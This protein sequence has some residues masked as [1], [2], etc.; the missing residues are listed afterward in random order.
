MTTIEDITVGGIRFLDSTSVGRKAGAFIF[1]GSQTPTDL[2]TGRLVLGLRDLPPEVKSQFATG[3][4]L[5]DAPDDR[6]LAQAWRIFTNVEQ[7]LRDLGSTLD[8]I[9]HQRI[10]LRE[11]RDLPSVERVLR[12]F[13]PSDWPST[14]V[15]GATSDGVDP[16]IQIQADFVVLAPGSGLQ[17]ESVKL[18]E[19][20]HLAAPY[21][22]ATRAGRYIFTTPLAG[23]NPQTG[24]L[25]QRL[26]E[27]TDEERAFT[28]PPY[29]PDQE[30]A[31]AQHMMLFRHIGA[32]LRSLGGTLQGQVRMNGWLRIPFQEFGPL[33]K[34]RRR[35]FSGPGMQV[36]AT[37][38]PMSG[39]RTKDA[40][41]EW[42]TIALLPATS[43][44]DPRKSITM[45]QHP[46]APYQVPALL[47]GPYLFT[48][49]EVAIDTSVPC[50]VSR[51]ADLP[52]DARFMLYGRIHAEHPIMAQT[53]FVY[54]K[55]RSYLEA[56]GLGMDRAL[57]Q[58]VYMVNPA[59]YPLVERVA[60]LFFGA[61]LPPTTIVP[62]RGVSPFRE[63]LLEIEITAVH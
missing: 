6:I 16:T 24:E 43:A 42:Q 50:V 11:M 9:V 49:G 33:A 15:I 40:L 20:D 57:Q 28:E 61:K 17:R 35:M 30:A 3:I 2:S 60:S 4:I 5:T 34:V 14:A 44:D 47:A 36:P 32:I 19:L 51:C 25:V 26:S 52:G 27:L 53:L 45:A 46:L 39:L 55:L 54:E 13:M 37:S 18:P 48:A 23:V 38:F 7:M 22:L 63:A 8:S 12:S 1:L 56:Y 21:P 41:F 62:I 10:F 59:D 58:T 31:V 29:S